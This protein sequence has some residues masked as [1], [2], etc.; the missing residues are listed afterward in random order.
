MVQPWSIF[1]PR[2]KHRHPVLTL[3][4]LGLL[5]L[6]FPTEGIASK[7]PMIAVSCKPSTAVSP[8]GAQVICSEILAH[9]QSKFSGYSFRAYNETA[10]AD[11]EVAIKVSIDSLTT[12]SLALSVIW[13]GSDGATTPG[14][15]LRFA[16]FDREVDAEM[17]SGF[18]NQFFDKNPIPF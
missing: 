9:L 11:T 4:L 12:T 8:T 15:P 16:V 6:G 14:M 5:H 2:I 3:T 18:Y 13:V 7:M 17:R 10:D 1:K